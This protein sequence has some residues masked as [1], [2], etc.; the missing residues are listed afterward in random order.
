M[1]N[2]NETNIEEKWLKFKV[3]ITEVAE[4]IVGKTEGRK[5]KRNEWFNVKCKN[6][7][8]I[9]TEAHRKMLQRNTRNSA[10]EYKRRRKEEN[11]KNKAKKKAHENQGMQNL[12]QL[13]SQ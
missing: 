8:A 11:L 9:K 13:H 10:K 6:I 7:T 4:R 2:A 1:K 12:E 3:N 5:T